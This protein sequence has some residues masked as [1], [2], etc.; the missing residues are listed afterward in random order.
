M[1]YVIEIRESL[2]DGDDYSESNYEFDTP[3]EVSDFIKNDL[4]EDERVHSVLYYAEGQTC[5][6]KDVT[7]KFRKNKF[8]LN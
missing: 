3:Q 6:P 8:G 1:S 4:S 5:N 2:H 7:H